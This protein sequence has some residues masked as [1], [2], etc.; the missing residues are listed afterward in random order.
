MLGAE[1]AGNILNVLQGEL[2]FLDG[3]GGGTGGDGATCLRVNGP[4]VLENVAAAAFDFDCRQNLVGDLVDPR[5]LSGLGVVVLDGLAVGVAVPVRPRTHG[6]G[7]TWAEGERAATSN[8]GF[9]VVGVVWSTEGWGDLHLRLVKGVKGLNDQPERALRRL[10]QV[11]ADRILVDALAAAD[12]FEVVIREEE[13]FRALLLGLF[14]RVREF[15]AGAKPFFLPTT[16]TTDLWGT[17]LDMALERII[18]LQSQSTT[19]SIHLLEK[20]NTKMPPKTRCQPRYFPQ[21]GHEDTKA[22]DGRK[23]GRY[24]VVGAGH[25]GNGVFTDAIV[26]NTQTDG[27]SGYV[28]RSAKRWTGLGG[29]EEI[30]ASFCD[31]LHQ[32]GC[33]TGRLPAGWDAPV[34][35]VRGCPP[36]AAAAPPAPAAAPPAAS[37]SAPRTPRSA[38]AGGSGNSWASPLIVRS[39]VSPSPLRPPPQYHPIAPNVSGSPHPRTALNPNGSVAS[40]SAGSSLLSATSSLTSSSS[41]SSSSSARTP[42]KAPTSTSH[43]RVQS[44]PNGGYDTD[45]FYDDD[46]GEESGPESSQTRFWAVRGLTTMFS[47]VD[48]AFDSLRQNM[49]HLKYMEVRTSTSLTKLRRFAAS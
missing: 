48:S 30:W 36:A 23:E 10:F 28:K 43:S 32:D 40:T 7:G 27:F 5:R 17:A 35:V 42:K 39:S 13:I 46:T 2:G 22:H 47:D 9:C 38:T 20:K 37:T 34:P 3:E 41:S 6:L 31:D 16:T 1:V 8:G 19:F 11:L 26:A 24:F 33:H 21:P 12:E 29:V 18:R 4:V 45:F 44:S 49:H 25:C 14:F 15:G